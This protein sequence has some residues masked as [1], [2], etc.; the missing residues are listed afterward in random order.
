MIT[1]EK[2]PGKSPGKSPKK[3]LISG[4]GAKSTKNR[5]SK[6]PGKSP[7]YSNILTWKQLPLQKMRT[8][9]IRA[10]LWSSN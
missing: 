8:H 1:C 7:K 10:S 5:P 6:K 2:S 9:F 3:A 4:W